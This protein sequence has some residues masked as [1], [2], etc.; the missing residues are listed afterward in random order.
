MISF[1]LDNEKKIC[2]Y[3]KDKE[4]PDL[5][6]IITNSKFDFFNAPNYYINYYYSINMHYTDI[7]ELKEK[8]DIFFLNKFFFLPNNNF[9]SIKT[10]ETFKRRKERTLFILHL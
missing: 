1:K 6:N 4:I 5:Q 9:N 3:N 7:N 10:M 8:D 2:Y